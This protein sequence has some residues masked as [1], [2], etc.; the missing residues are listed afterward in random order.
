MRHAPHIEENI[1]IFQ[2]LFRKHERKR[3]LGRIKHRW[4]IDSFGSE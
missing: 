1:T 3:T 2:I 4:E